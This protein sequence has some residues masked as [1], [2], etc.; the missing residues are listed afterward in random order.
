MSRREVTVITEMR[1]PLASYQLQTLE[2]QGV[3]IN[4][5]FV[6]LFINY[7]ITYLLVNFHWTKPNSPEYFSATLKVTT[8]VTRCYFA[9][10]LNLL[11]ISFR[12]RWICLFLR[13]H[14]Q[15]TKNQMLQARCLSEDVWY[16]S[17]HASLMFMPL[18]RLSISHRCHK[19]I[20]N[21]ASW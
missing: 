17:V 15:T 5:H 20:T 8:V 11:W 6:K 9:L 4:Q 10:A 3:G 21:S 16:L 18:K 14:L 13:L 12:D 7:L 1:T 2:G 19:Y